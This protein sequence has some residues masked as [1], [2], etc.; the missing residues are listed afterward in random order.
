MSSHDVPPRASDHKL[1][2]L[3]SEHGQSPWLDNINRRYLRDGTLARLVGDGIRG[4]TANPTIF[5]NAIG[6]SADYDDQLASLIAAGC[7]VE[8]AY[9]E[10]VVTDIND[11]LAVL[12]PVFE[13]SGGA[14]G[15]VSVEVAPELAHDTPATIA[16]ARRLHTRID[17]PNLLVK[18]PATAEGVPAIQAMIAEGRNINVTLIFS[19]TRYAEVIEA[20]LSG[21]ETF[22]ARRRRPVDGAQR[23]LLLRQPRRQRSRPPP[24]GAR[25]SEALGLRG[26]AGVAQAKLAYRLFRDRFAGARWERLA[27]LGAHRQR[28]LWASTSTKNPA[29]PDTLYVDSLIGPDTV[30]TLPEATIGHYED[31]GTLARTIDVD[32]DE[33][34]ETM[35]RLDALGIDMEAVGLTLENQ[36]V[37]SFHEASDRC[38]ATSKPRPV[39][40][41]QLDLRSATSRVTTGLARAGSPAARFALSGE[42]QARPGQLTAIHLDER[43]APAA[44]GC[45]Y[46]ARGLT[47]IRRGD[48]EA[49]RER[50]VAHTG[51]RPVGRLRPSGR[52]AGGASPRPC[53]GVCRWCSPTTRWWR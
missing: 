45:G 30:T 46:S 7:T 49:T 9:W 34:D 44:G 32:V 11:A 8:D 37:A 51:S 35:R 25:R 6:G 24:G 42:G 29:Y 31:H 17:E 47:P 26:R 21:L 36:G 52:R 38:S 18:I 22:T 14:D 2:R 43:P 28:P 53:A 19:L 1:H 15:F 12:R 39:A 27:A 33:A 23:R 50:R 48:A 10:L 3:H 40:S 41:P 20:Y 13:R 16:A 5:A 4:V